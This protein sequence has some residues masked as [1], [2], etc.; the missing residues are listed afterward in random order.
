MIKLEPPIVISHNFDKKKFAKLFAMYTWGTNPFDHCNRSLKKSYS[1]KFNK[2]NEEF[3]A[4][5]SVIMDEFPD[6]PWDAIYICG[7]RQGYWSKNKEKVYPHNVHFAIVPAPGKKDSWK[8]EEWEVHVENGTIETV[9]S[10][11]ELDPRFSSF[12]KD[13][14]T[15]RIYRWSVTH[16]RDQLEGMD[17]EQLKKD[18]ESHVERHKMGIEKRKIKMD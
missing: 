4:G 12:P 16:Y 7:V 14:T 6:K 8:F 18:A 3:K 5:K 13:C 10:E 15:C 1:E 11:E 9:L 17:F 2:K